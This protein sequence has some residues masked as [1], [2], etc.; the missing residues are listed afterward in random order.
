[1]LVVT[2]YRSTPNGYE[3]EFTVRGREAT[4][5]WADVNASYLTERHLLAEV[6]PGRWWATRTDTIYHVRHEEEE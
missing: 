5:L 6:S 2:Q 1:M 3:A 4:R